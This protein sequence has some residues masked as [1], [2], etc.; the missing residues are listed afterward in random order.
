[1]NSIDN[2]LAKLNKKVE[3]KIAKRLE[4]KLKLE[5]KENTRKPNEPN[6]LTAKQIKETRNK[7]GSGIYC[8]VCFKKENINKAHSVDHCHV[9]GKVRG[10]LCHKCNIGLGYFNEDVDLLHSAARYLIT[11]KLNPNDLTDEELE[12]LRSIQNR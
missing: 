12:R 1:M 3:N 10:I 9:T 4:K 2:R 11:H 5:S 8:E 6:Y 7:F